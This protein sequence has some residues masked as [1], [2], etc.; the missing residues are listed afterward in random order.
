M[1]DSTI[2]SN[3]KIDFEAKPPKKRRREPKNDFVASFRETPSTWSE[4]PVRIIPMWWL[5]QVGQNMT[6]VEYENDILIIDAGMMMP[7]WEVYW[8][9]YI[10]PDISYLKDKKDKIRWII[11][12]HGHLDH[13]WALKHIL[14]ELNYP[15]VYA[16]MLATWLIKKS[17]EWTPAMNAA[18]FQVVNPDI[19]I[20]SLW[21]FNVEFF[22]VNHSIPEPMG[23]SI[24]TP[25]WLVV[26]TWDFKIDFTPA[27]DKTADLAKIAR[28]WQ[29]W[30]KVLMSDSTNA[31]KPWKSPSELQVWQSLEQ[32]IKNSNSRLIIATFS[33]L[34]WRIA[35]IIDFAVKY[36][37]I[38][39]LSGRSMVNNIE[40]ARQLG[41][42]NAPQWII[43]KVNSDIDALPDDRVI[44]LTTGSQWEDFSALVRI[45]K[46]EHPQ[47]KIRPKDKILLSSVPIPGNEM[48]VVNM[49]NDLI[50][51]WADVITNKDLD[52]H[53]SGHGYQDDLR[54]ML[55]LVQ[56]Q[57]F[58]PV[59][60]D[61]YMR[62]AHKK[63]GTELGIEDEKTLLVENWSIIEVYD[64]K[65]K[66]APKRLK[67]DV[68]MIDWLGIGSM[69]GEYVMKARQIMSQDGMVA[70]IFKVDSKNK[71]LVWN[72]QIESR[73]FVY[74]AEVKKIHTNIV[75]FAKKRYYELLKQKKE[76]KDVL[77]ELKE[78]LNEFLTKTVG[79]VPM[80]I[81]MFVYINRDPAGNIKDDMPTEDALIWMTLDEQPETTDQI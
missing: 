31:T 56:P 9:D 61:L 29:E 15:K 65:V 64:D 33:S 48:A 23:L 55:S 32:I 78:E 1:I 63:I 41:Y 22:R 57:Y 67:M 59:H 46:W 2:N 16:S 4:K 35:Q 68:V 21:V 36:N 73:W 77:K 27:I 72:I 30:V 53:V 62:F 3:I 44:I 39:F 40:I 6:I 69:A 20:L 49:M 60:G 8:V 51:K 58:V 18:E 19:D 37:K 50:K 14:P 28:I 25:K 81:P 54:M 17:L 79:R 71:Q 74:S 43:R 52:L 13:I 47:I 80:I 24:Y 12:T 34:I 11:I 5:E 26:H 42:V 75:D 70:L 76:V 10:I 38:V 7:G 66:L 45:A